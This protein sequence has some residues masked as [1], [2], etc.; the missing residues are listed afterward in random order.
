MVI[1]QPAMLVF[2]GVYIWK[3]I[4]PH[5]WQQLPDSTIPQAKKTSTFFVTRTK[6]LHLHILYKT[7]W[8]HPAMIHGNISK[9]WPNNKSHSPKTPKHKQC[10]K[11]ALRSLCLGQR[12]S[13][14]EYFT[15]FFC[16]KGFNPPTHAHT[17][18]RINIPFCLKFIPSETCSSVIE[19]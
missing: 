2:R 13:F 12:P 8:F 14:P 17:N 15:L 4:D 19:Q 6:N 18:S 1:F 11:D 10:F 9:K 3:Y 7:S 5:D 16:S